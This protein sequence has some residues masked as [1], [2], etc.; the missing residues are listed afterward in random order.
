MSIRVK[1][2]RY[3]TKMKWNKFGTWIPLDISGDV[4]N[5]ANQALVQGAID[6]H[7]GP[8]RLMWHTGKL[9]TPVMEIVKKLE[10]MGGRLVAI[11]HHADG[12][13]W[14]ADVVFPLGVTTIRRYQS[15]KPKYRRFPPT[16]L[17]DVFSDSPPGV[18]DSDDED[19]EDPGSQIGNSNSD[20]ELFD[21]IEEYVKPLFSHSRSRRISML[22][23]TANGLSVQDLG[24]AGIPLVEENYDAAV[25]KDFRHVVADLNA[26]NPCGRISIFNGP[27]GTGKTYLI[28]ALTDLVPRVCFLLIPSSLVSELSGPSLAP[29]LLSYQRANNIPIVLVIEDADACLVSRAADNMGAVSSLLNIGD[30]IFGSIL[31]LRIVATTNAGHIG[32]A[33]LDPALLRPGRLCRRINIGPLSSMQAIDRYKQLGGKDGRAF[34][35][36]ATLAEVYKAAADSNSDSEPAPIIVVPNKMKV[37][38]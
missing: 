31:D 37:G 8:H 20:G 28:R 21:K 34:P 11:N 29:T 1:K 6:G 10:S 36:G 18:L 16:N 33:D 17:G 35:E 26:A 38:F 14:S 24:V 15:R 13:I 7:C 19:S 5:A 27:P 25:M 9:A 23:S 12:E 22:V 3:N 4:V 30:G 2:G 32:D